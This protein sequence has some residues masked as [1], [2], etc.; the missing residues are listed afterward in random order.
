MVKSRTILIILV[1]IL[2]FTPSAS[3]IPPALSIINNSK[4]NDTSI[5]KIFLNNSEPITF[6]VLTNN[7][8]MT[9]NWYKDGILQSNNYDNY[10]T[11]WSTGRYHY[12]SVNGTNANGSSNLLAWGINVYPAMVTTTIAALNETPYNEL[13]EAMRNK[14][15]PALVMATTLPFTNLIGAFFYAIVWFMVFVMLWIKQKSMNIPMV[16]GI[17]FGGLM[18]SFL[19][20]QYQLV[21]VALITL[22]IFAILYVFFKGR[23]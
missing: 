1:L 16:I 14:D 23:G 2:L 5:S 11:S 7:E 10:T 6:F 20:A 13:H 22:G 15:M 12:V 19:P 3:P 17:I 8:N 21:S 9:W 4:T 18:I